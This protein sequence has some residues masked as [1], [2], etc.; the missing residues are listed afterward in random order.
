MQHETT[1]DSQMEFGG[2]EFSGGG[3]GREF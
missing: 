2:G 3:S 1:T